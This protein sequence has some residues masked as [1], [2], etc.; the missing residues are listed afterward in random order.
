MVTDVCSDLSENPASLEN[1]EQDVCAGGRVED[2]EELRADISR[3]LTLC[4]ALPCVRYLWD[5]HT[6][7]SD[8]SNMIN[9]VSVRKTLSTEKRAA[10]M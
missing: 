7:L 9:P 8:E 4:Q 3:A 10:R 6:S 1:Q 2:A 5:P